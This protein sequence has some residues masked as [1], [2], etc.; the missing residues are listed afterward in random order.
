V[1]LCIKNLK[2][3]Y[4]SWEVKMK[5]RVFAF[6]LS[7]VI[8]WASLATFGH[9][10]YSSDGQHYSPAREN[11]TVAIAPKLGIAEQENIDHSLV[12]VGSFSLTRF[13]SL[14]QK[15]QSISPSIRKSIKAYIIF[16]VFRN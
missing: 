12:T 15:I 3:R 13:H 16:R 11:V 14:P 2:L 10:T 9:R 4:V 5:R 7:V 6:L 8:L 1:E